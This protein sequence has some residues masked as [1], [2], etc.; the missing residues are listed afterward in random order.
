MEFS[1]GFRI[2]D[3]GPYCCVFLAIYFQTLFV[4][5]IVNSRFLE[6]PQKRSRGNQFI[7]RRCPYYKL[8]RFVLSQIVFG[9]HE[10]YSGLHCFNL[11]RAMQYIC[12]GSGRDTSSEPRKTLMLQVTS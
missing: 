7:Y 4:I 1:S 9:G 10:L 5:V 11:E 12:N 6:R 8:D 2:L 3:L